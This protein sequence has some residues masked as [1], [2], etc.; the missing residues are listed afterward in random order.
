MQIIVA[1]WHTTEGAFMRNIFI[2]FFAL[3]VSPACAFEGPI[4]GG[5]G[6]LLFR[7]E[8]P[9][10]MFLVGFKAEPGA[11]INYML[12]TCQR[13]QPGVRR[14]GRAQRPN[15]QFHG[16]FKFTNDTDSIGVMGHG[17]EVSTPNLDTSDVQPRDR[18]NVTETCKPESML[19]GIDVDFVK[20]E[21][22]HV[23]NFL[24]GYC[25]NPT[26]RRRVTFIDVG[27]NDNQFVV[28]FKHRCPTGQYMTGIVGREGLYID[29]VGIICRNV[30]WRP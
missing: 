2:A 12:G 15:P 29:A 10:Q 11:W 8:C 18:P 16:H 14:V 23:L 22:T 6:G 13:V 4:T 24:R 7:Y 27:Q 21:N 26:T 28:P 30:Y 9:N 19:A 25:D 1:Q 17:P 3:I 5:R 20:Y